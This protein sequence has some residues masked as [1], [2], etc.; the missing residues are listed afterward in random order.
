MLQLKI[1]PCCKE[2]WRSCV[3]QLRPITAKYTNKYIFKMLFIYYW[4]GCPPFF[5]AALDG[6]KQM[7]RK[8]NHPNRSM[9]RAQWCMSG[10]GRILYSQRKRNHF[11][12][13]G[14]GRAR[15]VFV[16]EVALELGLENWNIFLH[17]LSAL[18]PHLFTSHALSAEAVARTKAGSMEQPEE[19]GI[20]CRIGGGSSSRHKSREIITVLECYT[21]EPGLCAE[22]SRWGF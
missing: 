15:K 16:K 4:S 12:L 20:S 5:L 7:N 8:H 11:Y 18:N 6:G 13:D 21:K 1:P 14:Q 3:L 19:P 9:I 2:D 22:R 10:L 17:C